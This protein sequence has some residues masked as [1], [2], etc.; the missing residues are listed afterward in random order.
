[1]S[2]TSRGTGRVKT[3]EATICLRH[4]SLPVKWRVQIAEAFYHL[5]MYRH[6]L[7]K[8]RSLTHQYSI[9]SSRSD[10]SRRKTKPTT[11]AS[12]KTTRILLVM[13]PNSALEVTIMHYRSNIRRPTKEIPLRIRKLTLA[14]LRTQPIHSLPCKPVEGLYGHLQI[15]DFR[16]LG[17]V[18]AKP[19]ERLSKHH[20]RGNSRPRHLCRIMQRPRRQPMGDTC[21]LTNRLVAKLNQPRTK[22]DR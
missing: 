13:P 10:K 16:V 14:F 11:V 3:V 20:H 8:G 9:A 21:H 4:R 15:V 5:R 2:R 12:W 17:L 7:T 6:M 22:R 1:M 19:R 18:V